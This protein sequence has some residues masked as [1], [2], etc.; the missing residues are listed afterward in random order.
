MKFLKF[1]CGCINF[2]SWRFIAKTHIVIEY[3][4]RP[5][6]NGTTISVSLCTDTSMHDTPVF[7]LV[8]NH[9]VLIRY[10]TICKDL[11]DQA[12]QFLII[13]LEVGRDLG[14]R[15]GLIYAR[16]K[17]KVVTNNYR[18]PLSFGNHKKPFFVFFFFLSF[19][20]FIY[21][22]FCFE[23]PSTVQIV[24]IISNGFQNF[25]W[26]VSLLV[27]LFFFWICIFT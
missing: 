3:L 8:S 9:N 4:P 12:S 11:G 22:F 1:H 23:F 14:C 24:H 18:C 17:I 13:F 7:A 10:C 20:F 2:K 16:V 21:S 6:S 27:S 15:C 19:L 5:M 25:L 26:L